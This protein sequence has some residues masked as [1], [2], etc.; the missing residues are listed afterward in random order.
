MAAL[1]SNF[2]RQ[3]FRLHEANCYEKPLSILKDQ[4]SDHT[5]RNPISILRLILK[6]Y[7][8]SFYT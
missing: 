6:I 4:R 3:E 7:A 1:P 8:N 5:L 2:A